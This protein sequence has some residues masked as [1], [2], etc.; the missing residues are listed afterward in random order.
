MTFK[1]MFMIHWH[2]L[3]IWIRGGKFHSYDKNK[4]QE[5]KSEWLVKT[6]K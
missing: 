6:R 1:I 5:V 4:Q 2:A 3:K